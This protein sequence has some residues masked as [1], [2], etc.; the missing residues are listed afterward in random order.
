VF[1]VYALLRCC[2]GRPHMASRSLLDAPSS[3]LPYGTGYFDAAGGDD[4]YS[5]VVATSFDVDRGS[6]SNG[7]DV[8]RTGARRPPTHLLGHRVKAVADGLASPSADAT[9]MTRRARGFGAALNFLLTAYVIELCAK[10]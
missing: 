9:R 4:P 3:P 2:M 8:I 5:A 1:A 7:D 6:S 10:V